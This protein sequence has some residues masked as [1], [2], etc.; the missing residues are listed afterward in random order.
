MHLPTHL[1]FVHMYVY[2]CVCVSHAL[3]P[4]FVLKDR[5]IKAQKGEGKGREEE[6]KENIV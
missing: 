6:Q 5:C 3:F 4:L 2:P 1:K